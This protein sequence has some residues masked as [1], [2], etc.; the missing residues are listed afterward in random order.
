MV[1]VCPS[2]PHSSK[3]YLFLQNIVF[4]RYPDLSEKLFKFLHSSAGITKQE[5]I[6]PS[7]FR[8]Q[9][10]KFLGIIPDSQLTELYV[11]VRAAEIYLSVTG[12]NVL[13]M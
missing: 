5:W 6:I 7:V 12:S 3:G 8:Q 1:Y 9:A 2:L 4:P 11:K 10:E 13:L